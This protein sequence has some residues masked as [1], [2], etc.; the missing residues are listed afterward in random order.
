MPHEFDILVR[1]KAE[2][3]IKF[4]LVHNNGILGYKFSSSE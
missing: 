1:S 4:Y 2:I 3:S